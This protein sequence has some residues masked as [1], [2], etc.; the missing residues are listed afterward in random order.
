MTS[1]IEMAPLKVFGVQVVILGRYPT[2]ETDYEIRWYFPERTNPETGY[3]EGQ[4]SV[5]IRVRL[6]RKHFH[7][8]AFAESW[9]LVP[10]VY[11]MEIWHEQGQL[12]SK[13]FDVTG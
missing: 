7:F 5:P 3:V 10:G 8:Y 1:T 11:R 13:S 6:G 12:C 4:F 9:E 2:P